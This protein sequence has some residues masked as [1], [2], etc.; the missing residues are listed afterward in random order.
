M[1]CAI[2]CKRAD[3]GSFYTPRIELNDLGVSPYFPDGTWCHREG[4]LNYYCLQHH[5]LPEVSYTQN[6]FILVSNFV[7]EFQIFKIPTA[8]NW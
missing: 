3:S 8:W 7:K 2:F 5:C 1:G 6:S 4:S